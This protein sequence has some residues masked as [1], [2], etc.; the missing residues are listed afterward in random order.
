MKL[1]L[2]RFIAFVLQLVLRL[3]YRIRIE[4]LD[5][6]VKEIGDHPD[7]VLF[8]PNHP[9]VVVDPL[10]VTCPLMKLGLRPMVT[11]Y[12]YFNRIFYPFMRLFRAFP[13]PNFSMSVNP[14]KV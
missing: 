9:A 11:E 5:T 10:M 12:M 8:L 1:Y 2:I 6:V 13:V 4:G 14:I 7:G 3:R